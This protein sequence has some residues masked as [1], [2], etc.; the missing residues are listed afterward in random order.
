MRRLAISILL[1]S[2]CLESPPA[3]PGGGP[4]PELPDGLIARYRMDSLEPDGVVEDAVGSNHGTCDEHCPVIAGEGQ[5]GGAFQFLGSADE[6]YVVIADSASLHL[7]AGTVAVWMNLATART[8]SIFSKPFGPAVANSLGLFYL[9]TEGVYF[10]VGDRTVQPPV[11][12]IALSQWIH[13][14]GT[15]DGDGGQLRLYIDGVEVGA[16][17]GFSLDFDGHEFLIGKELD[18]GSLGASFEGFL[19]DLQLYDRALSADEVQMLAAGS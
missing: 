11:D 15:W 12:T 1:L 5:L 2:G 18:D 17:S 16:G 8:G 7:D 19:D 10:E 3:G 14:A 9:E 4:D 6:T 13:L